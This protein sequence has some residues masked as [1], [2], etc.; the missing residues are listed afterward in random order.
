MRHDAF[1]F[2]IL[3]VVIKLWFLYHNLKRDQQ[4]ENL[5]RPQKVTRKSTELE[6]DTDSNN[7][8]FEIKKKN[9]NRCFP[10]VTKHRRV[11]LWLPQHQPFS[12]VNDAEYFIPAETRLLIW[13]KWCNRSSSV[14]DEESLWKYCYCL[15]LMSDLVTAVAFVRIVRVDRAAVGS[16][17]HLLASFM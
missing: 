8:S 17:C 13:R 10:V 15:V 1:V 4:M 2:G 11:G 14:N 3:G 7:C 6:L 5:T 16:R 12:L 9:K